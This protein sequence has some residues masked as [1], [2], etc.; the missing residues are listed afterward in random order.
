MALGFSHKTVN[1]FHKFFLDS[2]TDQEFNDFVGST[3]TNQNGDLFGG[4]EIELGIF[5][6]DILFLFLLNQKAIIIH[7]SEP[8]FSKRVCQVSFVY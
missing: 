8:R 2:S 7:T 6:W 3:V 4:L 1:R 5:G